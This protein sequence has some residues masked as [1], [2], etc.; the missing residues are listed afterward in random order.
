MEF[1]DQGARVFF[2]ANTN[3]YSSRSLPHT[4]DAIKKKTNNQMSQNQYLTTT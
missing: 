3:L 4:R 2:K 1:L